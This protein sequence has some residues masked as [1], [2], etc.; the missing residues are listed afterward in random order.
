MKQQLDERVLRRNRDAAATTPPPQQQPAE[1]RRVVVPS[2]LGL[3]AGAVRPGRTSDSARAGCGGDADVGVNA[4]V[5]IALRYQTMP[6]DA[7]R[8][9]LSPVEFG[10]TVLG[11]DFVRAQLV[12]LRSLIVDRQPDVIL[13]CGG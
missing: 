13:V 6:S 9:R 5:T 2:D 7:A 4:N 10:A 8:P 11:P 12:Q 3:A 1:D